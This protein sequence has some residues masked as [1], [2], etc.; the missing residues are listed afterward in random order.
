MILSIYSDTGG[1]PNVSLGNSTAVSTAAVTAV[2]GALADLI[3]FNFPAPINV[4]PSARVWAVL[5][6]TYAFSGTDLIAWII[7]N[8]SVLANEGENRFDGTSWNSASVNDFY[9]QEYAQAPTGGMI[10]KFYGG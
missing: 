4:S 9:F 7:S 5:S 1:V 6:G 2:S 10:G 3:T 8:G